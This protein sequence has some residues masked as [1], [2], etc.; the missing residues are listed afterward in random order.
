MKNVLAFVLF[1]SGLGALLPSVSAQDAQP[2]PAVDAA[3]TVDANDDAAVRALLGKNATVFGLI[4]SNHPSAKVGMT[5]IELAGGKFTVVSWKNSYA[6][7]GPDGPSKLYPK[8]QVLEITGTIEEYKGKLQI[9]LTDPSQAKVLPPP[10]AEGDAK[11]DGTKKGEEKPKAG[12][13]AAEKP[14]EK[15]AAKA[16][17]KPKAEGDAK[18]PVDSKKFF[19]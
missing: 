3:P 1:V 11:A 18:T 6:K 13:K 7:F 5:F 14:S 9:K 19:K 12:E 4:T 15:P 2:A 16:P 8:G 17:E 10:P